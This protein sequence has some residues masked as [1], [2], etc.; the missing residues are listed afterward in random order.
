MGE[1]AGVPGRRGVMGSGT[2]GVG[3]PDDVGGGASEG[4]GGG[5]TEGAHEVGCREGGRA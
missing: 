1:A 5:V 4:R 3:G 2:T